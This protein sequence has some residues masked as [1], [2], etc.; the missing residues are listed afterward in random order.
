[1]DSQ[2]VLGQSNRRRGEF[3]QAVVHSVHRTVSNPAMEDAVHSKIRQAVR[4][5]RNLATEAQR[6]K[7]EEKEGWRDE[8]RRTERTGKLYFSVSLSLFPSVFPS[9][10]L[11]GSVAD[12]IRI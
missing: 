8:R 11:C 2:N 1:M 9:L 6:H 4:L 3:V 5:N 7:E 10:C 12:S